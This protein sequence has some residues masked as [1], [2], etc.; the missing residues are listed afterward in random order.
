MTAHRRA[1]ENDVPQEKR[2]LPRKSALQKKYV[3]ALTAAV[4]ALTAGALA[5]PG[6]GTGHAGSHVDAPTAMLNP[7]INGAD[8]YAF[9]SPEAPDTVTL[10]ATYN[11]IT[12]PNAAGGILPP[13]LFGKDTR[14]DINID[15]DGDARADVVYRWTFTTEDR[16]KIPIGTVNGRVDGLD[17]PNLL[18]RQ[19]YTLE[20]IR[21]GASKV[22]VK[23]AVAAPARSGL[24]TMPDYAKLRREATVALPGGGRSYTGQ[25]A[26]PFFIDARVFALLKLGIDVPA[27]V[28]P[29]VFSNVNVMTVQVPKKLLALKGDPGRNPVVGVWAT[30]ARKSLRVDGGGEPGWVQV[31]RLGHSF[32]NEGFA[33]DSFLSAAGLLIG[34]PGGIAD[35]YNGSNP[36]NDAGWKPINDMVRKPNGPHFINLF[37]A[38]TVPPPAQP[39]EDLWQILMKGVGK[40]NGPVKGDLNSPLLNADTEPARVRAAEVLRLNM[41]TPLAKR[42]DNKGWLAGDKQGFPNGRRYDD[43]AT[44]IFSRMALGEPAGKGHPL[45]FAVSFADGPVPPVGKTFPYV[46]EPR[47]LP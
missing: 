28:N 35:Q 40:N 6:T 33:P 21:G 31:S 5:G 29:L 2:V 15:S 3:L 45:L 44:A 30:A 14:Y 36:L 42:P 12:L 4:T 46:S 16:R 13:A 37:H 24:V 32:F 26:D 7:D 17:D 1:P 11:P 18:L 23:N 39:R 9:T 41:G 43:D 47:A 38:L 27:P 8:L 20:E 22:L 34:T 10:T 25:A 19:H